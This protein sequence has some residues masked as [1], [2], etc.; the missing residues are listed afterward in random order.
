VTT[1]NL[2]K[3]FLPGLL[4][5]AVLLVSAYFSFRS[6]GTHQDVVEKVFGNEALLRT[7]EA[8][9]SVTAQRLHSRSFEEPTPD[10]LGS[11]DREKPIPLP[12]KTRQRLQRLLQRPSTYDWTPREK[13][14]IPDYGLLFTFHSGTQTVG[15]AF[16]FKCNL[17]GIFDGAGRVNTEG[18]FDPARTKFVAIAKAIYP[19]DPEIRDLE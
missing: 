5:A 11:Y 3:K 14:C 2:I 18:D 13:L 16:C 19:N 9:Q 17:L 12:V 6:P 1:V 15:V 7:F 4:I 10:P 8:S